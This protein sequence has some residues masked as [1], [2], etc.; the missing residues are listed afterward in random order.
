MMLIRRLGHGLLVVLASCAIARFAFTSQ[1][2]THQYI[3]YSNMNC[4]VV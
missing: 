3:E 4:I 1:G 2:L